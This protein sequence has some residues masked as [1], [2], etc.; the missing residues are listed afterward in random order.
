MDNLE[1][2]IA[3]QYANSPILMQ[4]VTNMNEYIDPNAN[5]DNFFNTIW[6]L[7]SATGFG[8]D[9]WGRILGVSRLFTIPG[10]FL[11]MGFSEAITN[12]QP[13]GQAP[14]FNGSVPNQNY[15]LQDTEFRKVL[16]VKALANISA[17]SIAAMNQLLRNLFVA[18]G[19]AFVA[20]PGNMT[21]ILIFEFLLQPFELAILE[22]SS[23]VPHPTGVKVSILQIDYNLVFGFHEM[24]VGVQTFG[25]GT[26]QTY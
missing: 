2:T 24:G 17:C 22:Q 25:S 23:V 21:L 14:F 20:D 6:N 11:F 4:L 19:K 12:S 13:F 18:R 7:N 10:P 16:F 3:A 15:F 5:L 26:L 9:I 1:Q 8:L